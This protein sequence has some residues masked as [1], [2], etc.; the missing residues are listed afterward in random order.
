MNYYYRNPPENKTRG[1]EEN[2][3][4]DVWMESGPINGVGAAGAPGGEL[5]KQATI[6]YTQLA[7]RVYVTNIALQITFHPH[8]PTV[9]DV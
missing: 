2:L 6:P 3:V 7:E 1:T 5:L 9:C 8:P 4:G